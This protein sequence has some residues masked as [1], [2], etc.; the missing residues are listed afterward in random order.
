M[1]GE[2]SSVEEVQIATILLCQTRQRNQEL[3]REK[4]PTAFLESEHQT[5]NHLTPVLQA[6]LGKHGWLQFIVKF[7]LVCTRDAD[8]ERKQCA[9]LTSQLIDFFHRYDQNRD[10]RETSLKY[11]ADFLKDGLRTVQHKKKKKGNI[12]T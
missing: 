9:I 1:L 7:G 2:S 5:P 11:T 6:N 10:K 3:S 8:K 4:K 12:F